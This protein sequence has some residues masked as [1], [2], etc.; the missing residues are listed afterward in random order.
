MYQ[1][2]I[3][4]ERANENALRGGNMGKGNLP[5]LPHN[6]SQFSLLADCE[7]NFQTYYDFMLFLHFC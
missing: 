4:Y 2:D 6:L 7:S 3:F 1:N 5:S